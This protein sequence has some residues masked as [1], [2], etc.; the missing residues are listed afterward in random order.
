MRKYLCCLVASLMCLIWAQAL[1]SSLEGYTPPVH[2]APYPASRSLEPLSERVVLV[3]VDG[4]RADTS[5][6][7]EFLNA[8]RAQGYHALARTGQPSYSRPAYAVLLT[9]ASQELTGV[10]LNSHSGRVELDTL[11]RSAKRSGKKTALIAHVWWNE[12]EGGDADVTWVYSDQ[13][14]KDPTT[15]R[16][17]LQQAITVLDYHE[18]DLVILHFC[19]VDTVGHAYGGASTEYLQAAK[20]VDSY[21]SALWSSMDPN[22]DTLIV[23]SDHGMMSKN[24]KGA[25]HGGYE[26]DV[27]TVPLVMAGRG[28]L[29]GQGSIH[30][31]VDIAPTIA[32]LLGIPSPSHTTGRV[33]WEALNAEPR[34]RAQFQLAEAERIAWLSAEYLKALGRNSSRQDSAEAASLYDAR[35]YEEAAALATANAERS[36]A[37][38]GTSRQ[39]RIAIGILLRTL[40]LLI[41]VLIVTRR[42]KKAAKML[43]PLLIP[44]LEF[45]ALTGL[46]YRF[47]PGNTFSLSVFPDA[48]LSTFFMIFAVPSYLALAI[49]SRRLVGQ[50]RPERLV[51]P[52]YSAYLGLFSVILVTAV[53]NGLW[54]T[55][56][57]PHMGIGFIQMGALL[58][59][60]FLLLPASVFAVFEMVWRRLQYRGITAM[61]RR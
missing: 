24:R 8:L 42:Y 36:L 50:P 40:V 29:R 28:I 15:D 53:I 46:F 23:T 60:G 19:Y 1:Q 10:V 20:T 38:M 37:A 56:Y 45:I 16:Q 21:I 11:L 59:G 9:G 12:L 14:S 49:V 31:Q 52:L 32:A 41:P 33:I 34:V 57:L 27:I 3:I 22:R 39:R 18:C 47:I 55:W 58:Q 7:M 4:L 5:A 17:A 44:A 26:K 2:S 43:K 35:R 51:L 54:V 25:G 30:Q 13:A 61:S 48:E 6:E